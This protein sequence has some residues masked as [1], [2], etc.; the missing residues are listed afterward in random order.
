[1]LKPRW[2]EKV[3]NVTVNLYTLFYLVD[4]KITQNTFLLQT[5]SHLLLSKQCIGI[6][7]LQKQKSFYVVNKILHSKH[8]C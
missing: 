6:A 7:K 5:V 4:P 1:M 2:K 8:Y 3:K